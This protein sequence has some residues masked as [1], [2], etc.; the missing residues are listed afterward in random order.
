MDTEVQWAR[1]VKMMREMKEDEIASSWLKF[2]SQIPSHDTARA[3]I[4][5]SQ[6][7]MI[8]KGVL[9]DSMNK[10][11][12]ADE[13]G[14]QPCAA[15]NNLLKKYSVLLEEHKLFIATCWELSPGT[16]RSVSIENVT[17]VTSE[18]GRDDRITIDSDSKDN[19]TTQ[20]R[21]ATDSIIPTKTRKAEEKPASAHVKEEITQKSSD[22]AS[23]ILQDKINTMMSVLN[24]IKDTLKH[25]STGSTT[26]LNEY[27]RMIG[28][29]NESI[30]DLNQKIQTESQ[31]SIDAMKLL[32]E[33]MELMHDQCQKNNEKILEISYSTARA[34]QLVSDE[35]SRHRN[36]LISQIHNLIEEIQSISDECDTISSQNYSYTLDT[37]LDEVQKTVHENMASTEKGIQTSI[38]E[39]FEKKLNSDIETIKNDL[40][41]KTSEIIEH[42]KQGV[43]ETINEIQA[44]NDESYNTTDSD[45][46]GSV[47]T[48]GINK[49]AQVYVNK[50]GRRSI[51]R[52][53]FHNKYD[54]SPYTADPRTHRGR[55][56]RSEL[57]R[58]GN[59]DEEAQKLKLERG[60][61]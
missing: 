22:A 2:S 47:T 15:L 30:R 51:P 46:D 59:N 38:D 50:K 28:E 9:K 37:A 56:K 20:R 19:T 61:R 54:D 13:L 34:V 26:V 58:N 40:K 10:Q 4:T 14:S 52:R 7:K 1:A 8:F 45:R 32:D 42:G 55:A 60:W 24:E 33:R 5:H 25:E 18:N 35:M 48:S 29:G 41:L 39:A 17:E 44:T 12:L 16:K 53:R 6:Y 11:Q 23:V 49:T 3:I 57:N 21:S 43:L 27:K 36:A 31:K